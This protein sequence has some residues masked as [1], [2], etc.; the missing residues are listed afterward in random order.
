MAAKLARGRFV[1]PGRR[2]VAHAWAWLP[3][4]ARAG[5]ALAERRAE[6]PAFA[7]IPFPGMAPTGDE[8]VAGLKRALGRS[9]RVARFPWPLV[10]LG[11]P[12]NP[13]FRELAEMR[14]LWDRPHRLDPAPLA[15]MLPDFAPT[16]EVDVYSELA[17]VV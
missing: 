10:R 13:M 1:Y 6:L 5:V 3:D 14:Y 9:F 17:A 12:F 16:P 7:D 8:M 15:A 4:A 2:D 11:A